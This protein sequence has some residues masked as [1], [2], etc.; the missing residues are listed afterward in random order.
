MPLSEAARAVIAADPAMLEAALTGGDDYEI[1]CTV[2]PAKA[3]GFR[4]AAAA[5]KVPVTEIGVIEAGEGA[6]F[7]DAGGAPLDLRPR[8]LQPLLNFVIPGPRSTRRNDKTG[9]GNRQTPEHETPCT[10]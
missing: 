10:T 4:A 2:P 3:D 1:V 9:T 6:R 5:V 7:L 8:L